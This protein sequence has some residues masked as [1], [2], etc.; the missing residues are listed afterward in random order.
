V[1][2]R[3]ALTARGVN[4]ETV[5]GETPAGE[6]K[7]TIP[8]FR[9]G[10][11]DCL[12]GADI[13]ITGF[14]IPQVDLI[15]LLRPTLSTSRYIQMVGRGTRKAAGKTNCLVLD[16]GGNVARHGP[17][18]NPAIR[19]AKSNGGGG[20]LVKVCPACK[21]FNALAATTCSATDPAFE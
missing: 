11:M 9:R 1:H 16:F 4:A 20:E 14:D 17:V 2:V 8:A 21:T 18:D 5:T 19:T 13:F 6:R 7:E 3:D 12:T 10:E 15:A